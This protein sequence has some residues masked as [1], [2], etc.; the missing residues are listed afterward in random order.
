MLQ[1][2]A[3]CC[4]I[5]SA[6]LWSRVRTRRPPLKI[7]RGAARWLDSCRQS[8]QLVPTAARAD[9]GV[10]V[11]VPLI[12]F[13]S[14][15]AAVARVP[16]SRRNSLPNN[17][18]ILFLFFPLHFKRNRWS[19]HYAAS[20]SPDLD[21]CSG[22]SS[23]NPTTP[24]FAVRQRKI[25]LARLR[26]SLR[27]DEMR[28]SFSDCPPPPSESHGQRKADSDFCPIFFNEEPVNEK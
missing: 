19:S 3:K 24:H 16:Q 12:H 15:P 9:V 21:A 1:N 18:R 6:F 27:I 5:E 22:S 2:V 7:P 23:R 26:I 28:D 17:R 8:G 25:L 11:S 20:R 4:K 13:W 10:D 14:A